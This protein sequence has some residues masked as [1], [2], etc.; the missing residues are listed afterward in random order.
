MKNVLI[1]GVSSGL[2]FGFAH[3]FLAQGWRVLGVS[4]RT[5]RELVGRE[6]FS[7]A[8]VDLEQLDEVCEK[9][10][11]LIDVTSLD[12]A[13]L[14]AGVLGGFGDMV[15]VGYDDIDRVMKINVWANKTILDLFLK[16]SISVEQIVAISSGASVSGARGWNVYGVS[17]AALNMLVKLY[18]KELPDTHICAL[19]PGLVD[20]AMQ[21]Y[22]CNLEAGQEYPTLERIQS[23][24]NTKSM[25]K[26]KKAA[27]YI[28]G[29]F[30]EIRETV[31]TGEYVDIRK[32][33]L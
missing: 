32:L 13:V 28:A 7:F 12:L 21:E 16:S 8:E 2:G 27:A 25:P 11:Q 24:R 5:P 10:A 22:L 9:L 3:W 29:C 18:A 14:N 20:S 19:A 6:N 31:E 1:T 30:P 4:R 33:P 23:V 15:D 17:K 26:P